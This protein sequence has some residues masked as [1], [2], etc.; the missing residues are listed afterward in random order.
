MHIYDVFDR[1]IYWQ[2]VFISKQHLQS[3]IWVLPSF[4]I[5]IELIQKSSCS[6]AFDELPFFY[7]KKVIAVIHSFKFAVFLQN[8]NCS[9]EILILIMIPPWFQAFLYWKK[10]AIWWHHFQPAVFSMTVSLFHGSTWSNP[11]VKETVYFT[12]LVAT[13][14][15]NKWS[16][17][18]SRKIEEYIY[19]RKTIVVLLL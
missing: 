1:Y 19:L 5:V 11:Q 16:V 6:N 15:H 14:H 18:D 12:T 3:Y 2:K 9:I 7:Y 13:I 8:K 10:S 17:V 4:F